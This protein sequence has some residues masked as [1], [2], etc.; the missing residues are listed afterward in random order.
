M[1]AQRHPDGPVLVVGSGLA[2]WSV[3]REFRKAAPG[4]MQDAV[5]GDKVA[6]EVLKSYSAYLRQQLRWAEFSDRA[7]WQARYT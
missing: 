7:Y 2:G 5:A 1:T 6:E 3:V 4:V